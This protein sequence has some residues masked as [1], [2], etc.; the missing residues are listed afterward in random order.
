MARQTRSM[1]LAPSPARPLPGLDP[2]LPYLAL[3]VAIGS[4]A[5]YI[6]AR[7]GPGS[8][9]LLAIIAAAV[10]SYGFLGWWAGRHRAAVSEPDPVRAPG[11]ETLSIAVAY[12]GLLGWMFRFGTLGI[13]LF[14][15]GLAAWVATFAISRY[16]RTDFEWLRRS[17]LPF[18]PLFV[19]VLAP[20]LFLAGP[21]LAI[22]MLVALPSGIIQ[23]LLLQLGVTARLE[24]V[25]GRREVAAVLAAIAFGLPHV[26]LDLGQA[27]GDW[28]LALANAFVL[29]VPIGLAFCLAYQR[30]R[31][32]LALGVIHGIVIA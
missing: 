8:L 31:A 19:G 24:A 25:T 20:K 29:Q 21:M 16:R 28:T 32:P 5:A 11:L 15:G 6:V 27:G 17:W 26:P 22:G 1:A 23:Q 18:L 30:H 9:E 12:L 2:R 13:A 10:S 4:A 14:L 7:R 3:A